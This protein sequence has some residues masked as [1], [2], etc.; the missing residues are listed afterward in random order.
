ML[1]IT[2]QTAQSADESSAAQLIKQSELDVTLV[3][4]NAHHFPL[5]HPLTIE[6]GSDDGPLYDPSTHSIT[7]PYAFILESID[8]L[9]KAGFEPSQASQ[10]AMDTLLHTLLHEMA[11]ALIAD[12]QIPIL[13][14][15]E[16]AADN[17]AAIM[18]INYV[19]QGDSAAI[20]AADIFALEAEG[21]PEYYELG[22]YI[23]EHSFDLQRYFA[24]LC[25]VYGSDPKKHKTLLDEV[26]KHFLSD[27][28][29]FCI[30]QFAVTNENW[31][32]YLKDD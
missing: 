5:N 17:L 8:Y 29:D 13:A 19:E 7:I 14:K 18:M 23:D 28:K 1:F 15:E 21:K 2:Y 26:E 16:D 27:R 3:E 32:F 20:N 30:E 6:Y 11:H 4:L 22:D 12:N 24:T 25:L 31:H 10:L 9:E